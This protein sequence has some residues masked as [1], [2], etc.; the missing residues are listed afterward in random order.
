MVD[1]LPAPGD[2]N[3]P[4]VDS[5]SGICNPAGELRNFQIGV[6]RR[7]CKQFVRKL[8][9]FIF[10]QAKPPELRQGFLRPEGVRNIEE[11]FQLGRGLVVHA[12]GFRGF[13][14]SP[15]HPLLPKLFGRHSRRV[16]ALCKDH[17][18]P[19]E[20]VFV[21]PSGKRKKLPQGVPVCRY[22]QEGLHI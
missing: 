6:A 20:I 2:L 13:L 18:L 12:D 3:R 11:L 1:V 15:V 22:P 8:P 7:R 10:R 19:G 16:G 21:E 9:A 5:H 4:Q 17:Y 14:D